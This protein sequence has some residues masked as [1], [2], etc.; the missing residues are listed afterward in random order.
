MARPEDTMHTTRK[1]FD[2]AR[3][4]GL[5]YLGLA[6]TGGIGH[7]A[8]RARLFAADDA[9][10]TLAN[11]VADAGTARAALVLELGVVVTQALAAV[12]FFRLFR[13]VNSVAAAALA[14]FGLVN[15]V[16]VLVRAACLATALDAALDPGTVGDAAGTV[17]ALY[18]LSGNLW[19]AAALFFGLWL[20]PMGWLVL[21]SGWMPR[22]LGWAL[23]AGGLGYLLSVPLGVL[24]P[25][26]RAVAEALAFPSVV[27]EIWMVLHLLIRGGSRHTARGQLAAAAVELGRAGRG[28]A[29]GTSSRG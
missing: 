10:R 13:P 17:Q 2:V 14:A 7:L 15:A 24:L 27:G 12:W 6:L 9:D 8:L 20:L 16:A 19:D 11:L 3:T 4:T 21:R 29:V 28:A 26:A 1:T 25:Q 23:Y 18:L 22:A 5:L